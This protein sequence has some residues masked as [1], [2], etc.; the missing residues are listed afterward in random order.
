MFSSYS[1]KAVAELKVIPYTHLSSKFLVA[2]KVMLYLYDL[3]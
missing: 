3:T 2:I 1:L